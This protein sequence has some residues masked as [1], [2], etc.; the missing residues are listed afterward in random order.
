M[1][2]ADAKTLQK[3]LLSVTILASVS[4]AQP[5]TT[6]DSLLTRGLSVQA[7]W[8][9]LAVRDEYL[10]REK[11][12]ATLPLIGVSWTDVRATWRYRFDL[13]Y[14]STKS[15]KNYNVSAEVD[16]ASLRLDVLFPFGEFFCIGPGTEIFVHSRTQHIAGEFKVSSM[17]W[18]LSTNV[19]AEATYPLGSSVKAEGGAFVS[20]F[21]Q[22]AKSTESGGPARFLTLFSALR[23]A[24]EIRLWFQFSESLSGYAGYRFEVTRITAWDY[25]LTGSDHAIFAL[26]YDL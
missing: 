14:Q 6:S 21:S 11:Y 4:T 9:Y 7:G 17:A 20:L 2:F 25:F 26:I 19:I 15:L 13:L 1:N 23:A 5:P 8:G 16:Q 10:S 12:S 22:T 3:V 18:L 24:G